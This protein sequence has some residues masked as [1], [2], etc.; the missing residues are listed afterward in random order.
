MYGTSR[1]LGRDLYFPPLLRGRLRWGKMP[2]VHPTLSSP[3]RGGGKL[4]ENPRLRRKDYFNPEGSGCIRFRPC[5]R[6]CLARVTW[7]SFRY[8]NM[9]T[10]PY[11]IRISLGFFSRYSQEYLP[12][13]SD[14]LPIAKIWVP[15]F[16]N[17]SNGGDIFMLEPGTHIEQLAWAA[18]STNFLFI[19][20]SLFTHPC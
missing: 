14:P 16:L 7:K 19:G 2:F 1:S 5:E 20:E 8:W 12:S 17:F 4:L 9:D 10:R 3:S 15:A 13:F 11:K 18:I 6:R